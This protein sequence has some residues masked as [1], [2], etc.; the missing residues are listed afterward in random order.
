MLFCPIYSTFLK[1]IAPN[2]STPS[3]NHN[4]KQWALPKLLKNI[5]RIL[6]LKSDDFIQYVVCSQCDSVYE[7]ASCVHTDK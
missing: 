2:E 7:L 4:T 5:Y 6:G 1:L 3:D